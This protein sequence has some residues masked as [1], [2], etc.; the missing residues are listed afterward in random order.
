[1]HTFAKFQDSSF[2]VAQVVSQN[3]ILNKSHI[4]KKGHWLGSRGQSSLEALYFKAFKGPGQGNF[5]HILTNLF[6]VKNLTTKT[7]I[8]ILLS[9]PGY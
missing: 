1:M 7:I 3:V 4:C 2:T 6:Q 9:H 8:T 5:E